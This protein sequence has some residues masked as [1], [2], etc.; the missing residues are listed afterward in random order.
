MIRII[1]SG[2]DNQNSI[3]G[4]YVCY[5]SDYEKFKPYFRKV[6]SDYHRVPEEATHQ[7]NWNLFSMEGSQSKGLLDFR[8]LGFNQEITMR[9]RVCR[10]L[11]DFPLTPGMSKQDRINLENKMFPIFN[12][13]KEI[14]KFEGCYYSLTPGHQ[15]YINRKKYLELIKEKF[16]FHDLTLNPN[17]RYSGIADD[18]PFGRGC[19]VSTDKQFLI[20]VGQEDH[21]KIIS[22]KKGFIFNEVFDKL[23]EGLDILNDITKLNFSYSKEFGIITSCPSNLGTAMR[24]SV[25]IKLPRLTGNGTNI[26]KAKEICKSLGFSIKR[27]NSENSSTVDAALFK[28][29]PLATFGLTE[30]QI[31]I[32]LYNGVKLLKEAEDAL[33]PVQ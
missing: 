19:F 16:I 7:S 18:W 21:L 9:L 30:A 11:I 32:S 6:I 10:N 22:T 28:I 14:E 33:P 23:K 2:L 3:M 31:V 8:N 17:F 4:C 29:S 5:P 26:Y 13:L 1:K 12:K 27:C 25:L 15:N 24:A 20:W